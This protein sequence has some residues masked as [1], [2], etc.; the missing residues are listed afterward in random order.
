MVTYEDYLYNCDVVSRD[1]FDEVIDN[2]PD[3]EIDFDSVTLYST[4]DED[5]TAEALINGILYTNWNN[6]LLDACNVDFDNRCF[7][8]DGVED[9]DELESIVAAFENWT[10]TNYE[11]IKKE[12]E[13]ESEE[14]KEQ[15]ERDSLI[16]Y[17]KELSTG[18]L[19]NIV[20][21]IKEKE[22]DN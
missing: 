10:I 7:D 14:I 15:K 11:D 2:L 17:L 18:E 5:S 20:E 1:I 21:S 13:E 4:D 8:L 9:F 3:M 12:L 19:K 6:S 22:N 16:S